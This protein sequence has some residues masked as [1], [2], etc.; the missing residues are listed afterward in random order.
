MA[1]HQSR[2]SLR[3]FT[4]IE[5]L[6]VLTIISILLGLVI[7]VAGPIRKQVAVYRAKT[8]VKAIEL[9]M[10]R[11]QIDNGFF[12]SA[13]SITKSGTEAY[14]GNPSD[15]GEHYKKSSRALFFALMGR[16][17]INSTTTANRGTEY[18]TDWK[19]SQTGDPGSESDAN[20]AELPSSADSYTV[21]GGLGDGYSYLKDP[22]GLPYGYYYVDEAATDPLEHSL[23]NQVSYDLWSTA[24][25]TKTPTGTDA[26]IAERWVTNWTH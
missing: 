3:A 22:F 10:T 24:G 11:F 1:P 16:K 15:S 19:E 13:D 25:E 21:G 20:P 18:L 4:L 6:V 7:G 17:S 8:E 9:A 5:M 12:P 2:P 26:Y 14:E 23:F